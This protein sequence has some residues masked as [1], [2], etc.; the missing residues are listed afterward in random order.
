ML[1]QTKPPS[2][3][4]Q[5]GSLW[6]PKMLLD[7]RARF[8]RG[9]ID[10]AA[11]TK[12]EDAAI[13]DALALQERVG[14]KFATDGEFRRRSYHSFFYR[15]LGDLS[16]DTV[17]GEDAKGGTETGTIGKRGSQPVALIRSRVQ[18]R[19]PINVSD[20]KFI[21]GNTTLIPKITI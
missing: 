10:Q 17:R 21:A 13:K 5:I 1:A 19:S 14:L 12:A 9:E 2:R 16:I 20:F 18:W 6:R 7:Q 15:Q 3:A 11:L 8:A 4:E